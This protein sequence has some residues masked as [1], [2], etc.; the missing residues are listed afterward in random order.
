MNLIP[1]LMLTR[2]LHF[3]LIFAGTYHVL[4]AQI[5]PLQNAHAHNDYEHKRPLL[6]ALEFGFTIVEA[7]VYAVDNE[8][9]VYHD[10]P[11]TIDKKRTLEKVYL[12]PLASHI[13]R[14]DGQVYPG[15]NGPFFLMVDFKSA[16]KPTYKV[17]ERYLQKYE[18]ILVRA[19]AEGDTGPVHV[20]ISGNRPSKR[21]L[22]G[23]SK[24]AVLDGRPSDLGKNI[25]PALMP[26]I[27]EHYKRHATWDGTGEMPA[28]DKAAISQL[29]ERV[30][31]E[32]KKL[33]L[34]AI[35]DTPAVWEA[36]LSLGVDYINTDRLQAYHEFMQQRGAE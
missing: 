20:F 35:P 33:R 23:N 29:A 25:S 10:L 3:S 22:A 11:E 9:Y 1:Y 8:L 14:N 26:I 32:G 30:H 31:G 34:W 28:K 16:A 27:S 6:D 24:F 5:F 4:P 17:L 12:A 36:L 2:I 18:H 15:D 7:D 21:V 13:E 19:S